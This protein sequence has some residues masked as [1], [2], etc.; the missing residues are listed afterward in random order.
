MPS[1]WRKWISQLAKSLPVDDA[2]LEVA[3][4]FG[5]EAAGLLYPT[6]QWEEARRT[7]AAVWDEKDL[8]PW[9]EASPQSTRHG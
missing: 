7:L 1:F 9:R 3:S 2:K 4:E 5:R 8:M 6:M